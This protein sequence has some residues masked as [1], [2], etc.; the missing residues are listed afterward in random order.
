MAETQLK[1]NTT[2]KP[3]EY[4]HRF[5]ARIV[6]EAATPLAVGS[7]EKD[8]LSDALVATDV[9]GLPYIPGTAVAG[10]LRSM[11]SP[12]QMFGYHDKDGGRGSEIIFTSAKILNHE[13]QPVD[14][15]NT[16][17]IKTD[18]LLKHYQEL[19]IRQHVR[20]SDKGV[21]EKGGK[22]DAEVVFA[23]TRFCFEVEMV[24][25]GEDWEAFKSVLK[26]LYDRSFRIGGSTR[27]GFGEVAVVDMKVLDL[28][29]KEDADLTTYINKSSALDTDFWKKRGEKLDNLEEKTKHKKGEWAIYTLSLMPESFFLFGSGFGDEEAD[30]TPVKAKKVV[31]SKGEGKLEENFVLIPATSVKGAL[32]HRVA[33]H[34]NRLNG[35]FADEL[36]ENKDVVGQCNHAVRALFGYEDKANNTIV[37]G[38]LIFSDVLWQ[39]EGEMQDKL[40]NHVYLDR[41]TNAGVSGALFSEK[42]TYGGGQNFELTISV[43]CEG[44]ER[45]CDKQAETKGQTNKV[46]EA[47]KCALEDIC[48]GMLPLGGGVNRGH[49][50]FTGTLKIEK[51]EK[52]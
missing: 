34:W 49:G 22:Y 43:D 14:G 23:G 28:N 17:A 24:S 3:K 27:N 36:P 18:Q 38:N 39:P 26:H 4:T 5:L 35:I 29:L 25:D 12:D 30:M 16:S 50:V 19:P 44:V 46:F 37:R 13:G 42:V 15:L 51:E 45:V 8:I 47:L 52:K 21:A 48:G 40:L 6:I 31:W 20:M 1:D 7:G 11:T 33:F 10:V 41:F 32:A 2:E 9:N